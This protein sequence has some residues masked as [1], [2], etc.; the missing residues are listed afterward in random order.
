MNPLLVLTQLILGNASDMQYGR[1][2]QDCESCEHRDLKVRDGGWCYIFK[3]VP[4]PTC[5][6]FKPHRSIKADAL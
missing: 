6:Q 2:P 3:T 1:T 5:A 4:T